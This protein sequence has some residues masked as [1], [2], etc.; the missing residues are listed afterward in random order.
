MIKPWVCFRDLH[1]AS[2]ERV[3]GGR[4]EAAM[5]V[6][7]RVVLGREYQGNTCSMLDV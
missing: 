3:R 7:L 2:K 4:I 1:H 6:R 5:Y